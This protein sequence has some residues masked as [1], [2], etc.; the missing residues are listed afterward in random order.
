MKNIGIFYG[1]TTGNT[2]DAAKQMQLAFGKDSAQIFNV[3][4]AKAS[5][6]EQF[7]NIILGASTWGIGDLQHNFEEFMTEINSANLE[8]K[9]IAIFGFGDQETYPDTFVDSIG[10]IYEGIKNKGCEIVGKI[11][12]NGYEYDESKAE[13]DGQFIG[14]P[15]DDENQSDLTNE[16]ISKW[17][18]QLKSEFK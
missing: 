6:I 7:T 2:E 8:G 11:S 15:L 4:N 14:L 5:D 3:A 17:V 13:V 1:S 10:L 12:T 9:R 18:E 16:R